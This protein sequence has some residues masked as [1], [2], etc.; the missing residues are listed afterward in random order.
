M[1][2]LH[3]DVLHCVELCLVFSLSG[4]VWCCIV[5]Y[6]VV[7]SG[8]IATELSFVVWSIVMLCCVE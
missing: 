2:S 5:L 7:L 1:L 8:F 4:I 3:S 6:S